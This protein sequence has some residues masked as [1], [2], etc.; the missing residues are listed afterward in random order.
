[1]SEEEKQSWGGKMKE[2][3]KHMPSIWIAS[4][5]VVLAVA[6][7]GMWMLTILLGSKE[8]KVEL[9][10]GYASVGALVAL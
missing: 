4:A 8:G 3:S 9:G 10:V 6:F 2:M 1:M 5:D 7:M